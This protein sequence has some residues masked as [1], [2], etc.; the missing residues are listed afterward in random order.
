MKTK[1]VSIVTARLSRFDRHYR[2][3]IEPAQFLKAA[4]RKLGKPVIR[5]GEGFRAYSFSHNVFDLLTVLI[6]SV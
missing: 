5:K 6:R 3:V 2:D 4:R 1:P